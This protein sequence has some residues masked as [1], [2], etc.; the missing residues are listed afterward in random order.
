[1]NV[2]KSNYLALSGGVGGA[3]LALGLSQLLQQRLAIV[4]NTGDDFLHLGLKIC[5]D[6]DTVMYTLAGISN[7]KLGWGLEN[8]SWNCMSGLKRYQQATWFQL[9]DQ[10][11]ATHIVRTDLL[12]QGLSLSE[13]TAQLCANLNIQSRIIPMSDDP[14]ATQVKLSDGSYLA[15]QNY[16]VEQQCQPQVCGFKFDGINQANVSPAFHACLDQPQLSAIIICPSNPFVSVDPIL[17]LAGVSQSLRDH[18]APVIAVSPI[19]GGMAIKGPTAKMMAELN[20]PQ[21]ALAIAQHYGDLLDGFII[22][23]QDKALQEDIEA[24][25][26]EVLTTNTLMKDLNDKIDL[27]KTCLDFAKRWSY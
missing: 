15:F 9:G 8:E 10:D 12:N 24:L 26:I 1:M 19:V 6:L 25:G 23:Q 11:L 13:V 17:S 4:A 2:T 22:D 27:A 16:F 5:P 7:P 14:V 20:M 18:P 3:K 21:S